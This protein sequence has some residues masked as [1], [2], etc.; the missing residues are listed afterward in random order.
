[1][2]LPL[3]LSP[4][5]AF[6]LHWDFDCIGIVV[7]FNVDDVCS[8]SG[9]V[10]PIPEIIIRPFFKFL[11]HP[12]FGRHAG[13]MKSFIGNGWSTIRTARSY[14]HP[15]RHILNR[16][17]DK[18]F[19]KKHKNKRPSSDMHN[20]DLRMNLQAS[21]TSFNFPWR[22]QISMTGNNSP[23]SGRLISVFETMRCWYYFLK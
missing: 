10:Y 3:K 19:L 23:L 17:F 12:T 11:V 16:T 20:I 15:N 14:G 7:I 2:T 6:C 8:I 13:R 1:M 18:Y 4:K 5:Y 22:I 9:C 21:Q